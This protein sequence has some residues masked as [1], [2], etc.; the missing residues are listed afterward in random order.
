ML[1]RRSLNSVATVKV[2]FSSYIRAI[3]W[4]CSCKF[5][6][7]DHPLPEVN[8]SFWK[9]AVSLYSLQLALSVQCCKKLFIFVLFS[10]ELVVLNKL[11]RLIFLKRC[12]YTDQDWLR[13]TIV[14]FRILRYFELKNMICPTAISNYFSFPLRVLESNLDLIGGSK[15]RIIYQKNSRN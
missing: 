3:R 11:K 5:F 8:L 15:N 12:L 7:R 2:P 9:K 13:D 14:T 1:I 6:F 4:R 10:V